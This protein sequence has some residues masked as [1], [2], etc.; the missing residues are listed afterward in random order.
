MLISFFVTLQNLVTDRIER[1]EK[2]A[3]AVE[4]GL[5]VALIAAVIIGAVG[6]LGVDVRDTFTAVETAIN[7]AG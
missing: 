1:D 5:M 3:T 7:G 2:G 4:Y 6:I